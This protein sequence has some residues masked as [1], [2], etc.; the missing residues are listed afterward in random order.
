MTYLNNVDEFE[1]TNIAMDA[2][3]NA[4]MGGTASDKTFYPVEVLVVCEQAPSII[5]LCTVS[6]GTNSPS[7]NNIMS[8]KLLTDLTTNKKI[9]RG[10]PLVPGASV[11]GVAA[12]STI[13]ARVSVGAT[14]GGVARVILLGF[15]IP[16]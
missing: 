15:Y 14:A 9:F 8:G 3:G 1:A 16:D 5:G 7:Y 2:V 12:S 6:V 11:S 4:I 13:Y 10:D